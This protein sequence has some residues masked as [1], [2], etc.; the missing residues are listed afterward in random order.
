MMLVL[1]S[2][3]AACAASG[4]LRQTVSLDGE[5]D[6]AEGA[7]DAVPAGGGMKPGGEGLTR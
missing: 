1:C 7:M 4:P 5:W 3:A 6:V 2:V